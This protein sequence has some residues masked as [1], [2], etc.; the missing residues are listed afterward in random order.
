MVFNCFALAALALPGPKVIVFSDAVV[1]FFTIWSTIFLSVYGNFFLPFFKYGSENILFIF[2]LAQSLYC[3]CIFF[4]NFF[5]NCLSNL[6]L[7]TNIFGVL[8]IRIAFS[9]L[10]TLLNRMFSSPFKNQS[11]VNLF[12]KASG[13]DFV[14]E[15]S[16]IESRIALEITA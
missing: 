7:S 13:C 4:V 6:L 9:T 10:P 14:F 1:F 3:N 12:V 5:S 11:L 15:N 8:I 16:S 2:F